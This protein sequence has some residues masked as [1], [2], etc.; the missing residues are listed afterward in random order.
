MLANKTVQILLPRPFDSAFDYSVSGDV[1]AEIGDY[2]SVPFGSKKMVGVV[3]SKESA[4]I[5]P[6]K[7]KPISE[8]HPLLPMPNKC[9]EFIEWVANYT[10]SAKGS[11]L[12]M[13]IPVSGAFSP[14]KRK[15]KGKPEPEI[16]V[17][18]KNQLSDAQY[19]AA[20]ILINQKEYKVTL[21]DG[22]TGSGKT[23]VYFEAI[24]KRI[25]D[26]KQ[27]LVLLPE[28]V[29]TSQLTRRFEKRFGFKPVEWHSGLTPARRREN[30]LKI[31]KGETKLII[32]ARSALFLPYPEL[33]II[34][35]DEEHE[36]AFKQEDG[37]V[38]H[39][40][41]MAIVRAR[42]ENIPIVLCSASPS[43]E[44]MVNVRSGKYGYL[45]LPNRHGNA[46]FPEITAVDMRIEKLDSKHFLSSKLKEALLENMEYGEQSMLFLNRRGYAPLTLCR[47]C[48]YRFKCPECSA[49]L[50]EHKKP[51][52]LS[53][54]HCG[55]NSHIPKKCPSCEVENSFAAC[56]PGVERVEEEVREF[57]PEAR[58]AIMTSD[59]IENAKEAGG[60]IKDIEQGK[61]DIIIGTQMVAKGHHFPKLTL[62]GVVDADLGLAGGDLRAAEKSYQLLHQVSGRAGREDLRGRAIIQTY[63]PENP[64]FK[65]LIKGNREKFLDEEIKLRKESNMPPFSRLAAIIISGKDENA[66]RNMAKKLAMNAP[67]I[68]G[69]RILGPAEAPIYMLR[70]NFRQ[71]LLVIADRSISL[72]KLVN[73]WINK[74]KTPST[75]RLKIDI[76][77]YNFM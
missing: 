40:R 60:V 56:G 28:I 21:L 29:L 71:R 9:R 37:V 10:I 46:E 66:V 14:P 23:E 55:Y 11:V 77:P 38:Y 3:W 32:G 62:V 68:K 34:I 49:W 20:E 35:V 67:Q 64:L 16:S 50:V 76:D 42:I 44:T 15:I 52:R 74:E 33:G 70:G 61:I 65:A 2:V 22:V 12:A 39:G 69:T 75:M 4:S 36:S 26:G 48:G 72:Q 43:I 19:A 58:I 41:D 63:M 27:A 59:N 6:K 45:H 5:D 18:N 51:Q 54:H 24:A 47:K 31:I 73:N 25:A 30:W 57:L 13:A 1:E 8:K 7:I 53:C 17:P